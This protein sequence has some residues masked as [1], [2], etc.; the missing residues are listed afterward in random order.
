[1]LT[2]YQQLR[3]R[4]SSAIWATLRKLLPGPYVEFKVRSERSS[5]AQQVVAVYIAGEAVGALLQT[6]VGDRLGRIRE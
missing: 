2:G 5:N 1:M 3:T 4:A 6:F